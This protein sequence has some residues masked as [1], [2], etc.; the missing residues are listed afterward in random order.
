V[1][2]NEYTNRDI[3]WGNRADLKPASDDDIEKGMMAH[4]LTVVEVRQVNGAWMVIQDSPLNRRITPRSEM[5]LDGAAA[6]HALL[7]T[8]ADPTGTRSLGTWN[9]CGNGETPWGT[10]LACEENFNGYFSAADES[11]EVSPALKRYGVSA[12][13]WGYGWAKVDAR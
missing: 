6:G 5:I 3:I 1:L 12:E 11:H 8:A 2:N 9:N 7:K 4:G 10:Y 13:D